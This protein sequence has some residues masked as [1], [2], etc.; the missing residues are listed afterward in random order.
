[1]FVVRCCPRVAL[2]VPEILRSPAA[3]WSSTYPR[4]AWRLTG[5]A[6][7]DCSCSM[8][9]EGAECARRSSLMRSQWWAHSNEGAWRSG[10]G[11][12]SSASRVMVAGL[13][14]RGHAGQSQRRWWCPS[15]LL[16]QRC[17]TRRNGELI[18]EMSCVSVLHIRCRDFCA[19]LIDAGRSRRRLLCFCK[20]SSGWGPSTCRG[21][22]LPPSRRRLRRSP[23]PSVYYRTTASD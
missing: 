3:S 11:V 19:L 9:P 17:T 23:R 14:R 8:L 22:G 10:G 2:L 12:S 21:N 15:R 13:G 18:L 5:S 1:M 16:P 6:S 20:V 4:C 7:L